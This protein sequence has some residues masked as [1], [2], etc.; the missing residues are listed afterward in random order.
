VCQDIA[1]AS[2]SVELALKRGDAIEIKSLSS[3]VIY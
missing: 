2:D 1:V 3:K